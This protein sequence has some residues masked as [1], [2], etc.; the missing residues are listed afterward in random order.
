MGAE[1]LI[2]LAVVHLYELRLVLL[3]GFRA[4]FAGLNLGPENPPLKP[5]KPS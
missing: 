3:A 2:I 5:I 1:V 4:G